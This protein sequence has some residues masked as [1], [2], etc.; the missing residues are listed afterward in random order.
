MA[1]K[2]STA[3]V[4]LLLLLVAGIVTW[5]FVA[6]P[7]HRQAPP[8]PAPAPA[9]EPGCQDLGSVDFNVTTKGPDVRADDKLDC[10]KL[11]AAD[12]QCKAAVFVPSI[13]AGSS[14]CFFKVGDVRSGGTC[15]APLCNAMCAPS[16]S[17]S[18]DFPPPGSGPSPPS[19][20]KP[21]G[22]GH[23][24]IFTSVCNAAP[25]ASVQDC[26]NACGSAPSCRAAVFRTESGQSTCSLKSGEDLRTVPCENCT[27]ICKPGADC[28]TLPPYV[29]ST[30]APA[31]P[32]D[33]LSDSCKA[34]LV[35]RKF[36]TPDNIADHLSKYQEN[37]LQQW[38]YPCTPDETARN[39]YEP[40]T[41]PQYG[42][43]DTAA[44]RQRFG[45]PA[46]LAPECC[47]WVPHFNW[48]VATCEKTAGQGS[49]QFCSSKGQDLPDACLKDAVQLNYVA[50][51]QYDASKAKFVLMP[52]S[53]CGDLSDKGVGGQYPDS[54]WEKHKSQFTFPGGDWTTK[55]AP[56]CAQG[57]AQEGPRGGTPPAM[58]FVLSAEN[59]YYGAFYMLLQITLN[60]GKWGG[61][62]TNCWIWED[63]P[64]E[65]ALGWTPGN[66][67][68]GVINML[69]NSNAAQTSGAMPMAYS[70][71]QSNF[72]KDRFGFY[73]EFFR[74][75]CQQ[76]ENKNVPGCGAGGAEVYW[77]GGSGGG[78]RFEQGWKQP[79]VFVHLIDAL[80]YWTYRFIPDEKGNIPWEGLSQH[81][82]AAEVAAAPTPLLGP[83]FADAFVQPAKPQQK[84]AVQLL[85]AL[86]PDALC[87]RA[88]GEQANWDWASSVLGSIT[89]QLY[90]NDAEKVP[91]KLKGAHNLWAYF[92]DTLQLPRAPTDAS[93]ALYPAS[94]MGSPTPPV[95]TKCNDVQTVTACPCKV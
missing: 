27:A 74:K 64:V 20:C 65:G 35:D 37:C 83:T 67:A 85:P 4:L 91:D 21:V 79:Y 16:P 90:K 71:G 38:E 44:L 86:Q 92:V 80:G 53:T 30:Y 23:F 11:C 13:P 40:P 76:P 81:F 61:A 55:Y 78:T 46:V 94:I 75:F 41:K 54:G 7:G 18:C 31:T 42:G 32:P 93:L 8:A 48:V 87:A 69:V 24:D 14:N 25:A 19:N 82:A 70:S 72:Y 29:E 49:G 47:G 28:S 2:S 15:L 34:Y 43:P 89:W 95:P 84:Y 45:N 39:K 33:G 68:S 59:F 9:P 36:Y 50:A 1:P 12:S 51:Y 60:I 52:D 63:D 22:G 10:C 88:L 17:N 3:V 5:Y 66:P 6:G 77:S 56:T 58:M 62:S 73:P 26:C 57:K